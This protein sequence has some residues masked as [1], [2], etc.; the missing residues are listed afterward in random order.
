MPV[1]R[2][3]PRELVRVDGEQRARCGWRAA[4]VRLLH[5]LERVVVAHDGL[6]ERHPA[7]EAVHAHLQLRLV[8]GRAVG[9]VVSV[10]DVRVRYPEKR[11]GLTLR[12]V[13]RG[14]DVLEGHAHL[15]F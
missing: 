15:V 10:S 4:R 3:R 5:D 7:E 14:V 11:S 8:C 1:H 9:V 6:V 2:R 13:A 12:D